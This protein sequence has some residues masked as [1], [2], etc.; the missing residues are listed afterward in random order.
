MLVSLRLVILLFVQSPMLVSTLRKHN[1]QGSKQLALMLS[2]AYCDHGFLE[3]LKKE[4]TADGFYCFNA[5]LR[6]ICL[7]LNVYL[8]PSYFRYP[9]LVVLD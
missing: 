6:P 1:T 5:P 9:I 8:G 2:L 4:T 7:A 3:G